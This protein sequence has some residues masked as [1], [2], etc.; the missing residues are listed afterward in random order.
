MK[1]MWFLFLLKRVTFSCFLAYEGKRMS[2]GLVIL[3]LI[4]QGNIGADLGQSI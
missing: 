4:S 1:N 3:K 2:S